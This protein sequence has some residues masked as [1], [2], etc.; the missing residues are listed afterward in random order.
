MINSMSVQ[1][2]LK[3]RH[4]P[5][6][7]ARC[8]NTGTGKTQTQQARAIKTTD[9][10]EIIIPKAIPRS[11]TAVLETLS[12]L[13]GRDPTAPHYK[14]V[15]DPYL[16]PMS[17]IGKRTFG[18]A[19]ESG[20]KAARWVLENNSELF[21]HRVAQ[22]QID[23]YLPKV[24]FKE[25]SPVEERD[26]KNLIGMR[27]VNDAIFVYNLLKSKNIEL[28]EATKLD[29]L[30]LLSFYNCE[31][32]LN[33]DYI[34]ERWFQQNIKAREKFRKTWKDG[35]LPEKI[36]AE[37]E[38]KNS[39]AYCSLI[40]G[41]CKYYQAEKGYALFQEAL[42]KGIELD[43]DTFNHVISVT[44]LLRESADLRWE[45][46]L[47]LLRLMKER[48]VAPNLRTL[49]AVLK[50]TS[51]LGYTKLAKQCMMKTLAEFKKLDI[52]PSLASWYYVLITFCKERGPVSHILVDIMKE[53]EGKEFEIQD[54]TDTCFFA[55]AM[56]ICR[57]HLGDKNLAKRVDKLLRTGNNQRFI[58]DSYKESIY[59][60]H[61]I[62]LLCNT[63]PLEEFMKIYED[64]TPNVYSPEP[65]IM[66]EIL[67]TIATAG[68]IEYVPKLWSDMICFD[69]VGRENLVSDILQI[70]VNNPPSPEVSQH[71]DLVEKFNTVAYS[72]WETLKEQQEIRSERFQWSGPILG[73]I[74]LVL[75]RG[76][77][78]EKATEVFEKIDKS[79]NELVGEPAPAALEEYVKLCI[80]EKSPTLAINAVQYMVDNGYAEA[81][82]AGLLVSES[83]TL[84][85]VQSSKLNRLIGKK[86]M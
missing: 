12:S 24:V 3:I 13:V 11:E 48:N 65:G 7:Y 78:F 66:A 82:A 20:R 58:G 1:N 76:G 9:E 2:I 62:A 74:L 61:Y 69:H 85:D 21:N 52:E 72:V 80:T 63:E 70:M 10:D 68:T 77:S 60:R 39:A 56:D 40:R 31:E 57:N 5:Q 44:N 23:S 53:I 14:F 30:Q 50:A 33:E 71:V 84:D 55:T 75:S 32:Q 41:M 43:T 81:K 42:D 86:G 67:R 6:K 17:N 22:P 79:E 47:E 46:V 28:S 26:L 83:F 59:Y 29:L 38:T 35:E 37:L 19:R 25:D 54:P 15:D 4:I 45:L 36:F 8:I 27:Q 16:I 64:L 51:L 34:E 18:L 73:D 49:N